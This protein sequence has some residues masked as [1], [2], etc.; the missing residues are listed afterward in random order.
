MGIARKTIATDD[1]PEDRCMAELVEELKRALPPLL[2]RPQLKKY[3][4]PYSDGYMANLDSVGLGPKR[5]RCG[6]RVVYLRDS[7]IEWLI[8]R[9]R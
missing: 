9:A 3:G 2:P 8:S 1:V 5:I 6:S 7:L 4:W